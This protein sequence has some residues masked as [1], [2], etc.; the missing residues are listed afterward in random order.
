M[1][2]RTHRNSQLFSM[3]NENATRALSSQ[4]PGGITSFLN[5]DDD[6]HRMSFNGGMEM[7]SPVARSYA[8]AG[9]DNGFPTLTKTSDGLK[10]NSAALDLATSKFTDDEN[11]LAGGRVRPN[12]HSMPQ[13]DSSM[14]RP[15][16]SN[17]NSPPSERSAELSGGKS[18]R[19]SMGYSFYDDGKDG[20]AKAASATSLVRPSL[21]ESSYS[22]PAVPTMKNTNIEHITTPPKSHAEQQFH[23]HNVSM[24]RIPANGL[25]NRQSRDLPTNMMANMKLDDKQLFNGQAMSQAQAQSNL[26]ASA[27]PFGP[28]FTSSD[29]GMMSPTSP[30]QTNLSSPQTYAYS[31]QNFNVSQIGTAQLGINGALGA[32]SPQAAN[33]YGQ[34][35]N[36]TVFPPYNKGPT[37]DGSVRGNGRRAHNNM[38]DDGRY[39]N[40]PLESY[41]GSMYDMCKDQHGCRYMQR[42]LEDGNAEHIQLIFLETCP[43]IIELMTDPFGNYLCQ[44]LFEHCNDEQRTQ[45]IN[46]ASSALT[47]IALNQH[48]TRALQKMI[49]YVN[50]DEQVET[51]VQSLSPR[52]VELVQDLN[53]NHVVQ[54]CLNR[55]GAERCQ[56]IYDAVGNNC[57]IVG[58]HRHG[59]CVLQRCI[60]HAAGYQRAQLIARITHCAFDLV[61]DP[62]GN[63][64][65]Q[66]ILDLDEPQFTQPLCLSFLGKIA[67]LSKQKFSSNVIEK[68]LRTADPET[69]RALIDEMIKGN[70]LEKML[71]DSFANYVVQTALDYADPTTRARIVECIKPIL[72]QIKQTPHGRRVVSK[73]LGTET[74]SGRMSGHS[75]GQ[76]TPNDNFSNPGSFA[77]RSGP[78]GSGRRH[79]DYQIVG[80]G[81]NTPRHAGTAGNG[82][83][84]A[85]NTNG[86][87]AGAMN[88]HSV[89]NEFE[90]PAMYNAQTFGAQNPYSAFQ[91]QM[92]SNYF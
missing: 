28:S 37:Q 52:V 67:P 62:F 53:G 86:Y 21:P 19:L 6:D 33:M 73:V 18:Q 9:G 14:Y 4:A 43:H 87:N 92:G 82:V 2:A 20:Q 51:I 54:K 89:V 1:P 49:E 81:F 47:V 24:G 72:P 75:S 11:W 15:V 45:L 41:C 91:G 55:L 23:K 85:Y 42:K 66:Y 38:S 64:V 27:A 16:L 3:E 22:T 58:T 26:Q 34:Y 50:T 78:T 90:S 30:A 56:F 63:Y 60:D 76:M 29:A 25:S 5:D 70:E 83:E 74:P 69:K 35:A 36:G 79:R 10:T 61:Q 32:F 40:V 71:R 77:G 88:G 84:T 31:M 80:G 57:V 65:V 59:C 7:T 44:K 8:Q 12:H 17:L 68:C 48:G 13:T 46:S 39:N